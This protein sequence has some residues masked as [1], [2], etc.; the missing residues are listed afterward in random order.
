MTVRLYKQQ[1]KDGTESP[2]WS[3]DIRTA[4]GRRIRKSTRMRDK[5]AARRLA[6]E[7]ERGQEHAVADAAAGIER[8]SD[9]AMVDLAGHYLADLEK[10]RQP[11][12]YRVAEQH[13]RVRIL[14]Y[15]GIDTQAA[16]VTRVAVE[17]F[18]RSLLSGTAPAASK[19]KR[20]RP[21]EPMGAAT[22]NRHL[23]TLRRMFKFGQRQGWLRVN[24]AENLEPLQEREVERH[25]A[26]TEHEVSALLAALAE[27]RDG[28]RYEAQR[29]DHIRWVR[30]LI[31]TGLREDE[32]AQLRWEHID[33]SLNRIKV[34]G[35]GAK[36]GR[37][38]NVPLV[39]DALMV[40]AEIADGAETVGLVFGPC[41][42]R[43]ALMAAWARTKLPGRAPTAHD[44]RHT[45][46]SR[47][48][49]AGLDIEQL[50]IILGH[51]SIITTQRY[52]HAYSGRWEEM[53][54]KLDAEPAGG[55]T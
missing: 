52:V 8:P 4:D 7:W 53:A 26:L 19:D 5:S 27:G 21:Q 54:E 44:L 38:R 55:W 34:E 28:E 40:L 22:C 2:F 10:K 24:P 15:F 49:A 45:F 39:R 37:S 20:F 1:K 32:A 42:R 11:G 14:P 36:S 51:R 47:A 13:V 6:R 23:V 31:V 3:A 43:K 9:I 46:A 16:T 12:Y 18:R 41:N 35:L 25:R 33:W 50:R 48:I 30:F 17:G 29:A